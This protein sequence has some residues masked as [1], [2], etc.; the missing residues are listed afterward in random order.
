MPVVFGVQKVVT[1]DNMEK[2]LKHQLLNKIKRVNNKY[3][4]KVFS[5]LRDYRCISICMQK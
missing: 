2:C 1:G 4:I 3:S 5:V